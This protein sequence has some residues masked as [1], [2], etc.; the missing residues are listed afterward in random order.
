MARSDLVVHV[1][2]RL[3]ANR[4]AFHLDKKT[5]RMA[6]AFSLKTFVEVFNKLKT[7]EVHGDLLVLKG[8]EGPLCGLEKI[9]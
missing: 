2:Y 3:E 5:L 7:W 8:A 9:R 4:I 1:S 6:E